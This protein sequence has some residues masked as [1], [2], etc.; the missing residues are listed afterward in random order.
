[1]PVIMNYDWQGVGTVLPSGHRI[2]EAHAHQ[3]VEGLPWAVADDSGGTPD[4]TQ[5]GVLWLDRSRPLQIS[6][7][8]C[9]VPVISEDG[10][11]TAVG[12]G[13]ATILML[14][15]MFEWSI[16]DEQRGA[17]YNERQPSKVDLS[18]G[19][20]VALH[21]TALDFDR[22]QQACRNHLRRFE[23]QVRGGSD[24]TASFTINIPERDRT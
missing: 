20:R 23:E 11:K 17:Y 14:A 22:V 4:Q 13:G 1:M 19:R 12:C 21:G 8:F 3:P 10:D 16:N 15:R 5:D 2:F 18:D 6:E 24:P 9:T 7:T